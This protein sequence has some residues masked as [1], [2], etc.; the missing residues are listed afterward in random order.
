[1]SGTAPPQASTFSSPIAP[2][3]HPLSKAPANL[4]GLGVWGDPSTSFICRGGHGV[5]APSGLGSAPVWEYLAGVSVCLQT[6][7]E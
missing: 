3:L 6:E 4:A 7:W 1:M 2:A 5:G